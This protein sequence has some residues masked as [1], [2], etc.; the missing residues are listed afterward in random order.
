VG[1]FRNSQREVVPVHAIKVFLEVHVRLHASFTSARNEVSGQLHA[2]T[3]LLPRREPRN[4]LNRWLAGYKIR[5]V[6]FEEDINLL[7]LTDM[8]DSSDVQPAA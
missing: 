8:E 6:R 4:A 2:P 7:L 3:S 1:P 5:S